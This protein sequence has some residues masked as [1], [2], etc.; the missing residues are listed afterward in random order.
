VTKLTPHQRRERLRESL[1]Q[2]KNP[3]EIEEEYVRAIYVIEKELGHFIDYN[4]PL[5]K[6]WEEIEQYQWYKKQEQR[7]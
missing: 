7:E 1:K 2:A 4:Y 5:I 6:F 3:D